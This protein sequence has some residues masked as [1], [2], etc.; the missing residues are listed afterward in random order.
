M[1]SRSADLRQN[2]I[3]GGDLDAI[4]ELPM[5]DRDFANSGRRHSKD[6]VRHSTSAATFLAV[7]FG[8]A[9]KWPRLRGDWLLGPDTFHVPSTHRVNV[10][11]KLYCGSIL[12][13][14]VTGAKA[15]LMASASS[16]R[17]FSESSTA[18]SISALPSAP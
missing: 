10:A 17:C 11:R 6:T 15:V 3:I 14:H 13:I 8:L 7:W 12:I 9:T 18:L 2:A 1:S 4:D 16:W 5:P